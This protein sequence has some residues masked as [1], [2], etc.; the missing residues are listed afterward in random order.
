MRNRSVELRADRPA[1][2]VLVVVVVSVLSILLT[3]C[4]GDDV[5]AD[6]TPGFSASETTVDRSR[7]E[8]ASPDTTAG[9]T[10]IPGPGPTIEGQQPRR[11]RQEDEP[12]F[13]TTTTS[14]TTT[15]TT[16]LPERVPEPTS[17]DRVCRSFFHV[18][19]AVR[20]GQK[21]FLR[22]QEQPG[23]VQYRQIREVVVDGLGAAERTLAP[24]VSGPLGRDVPSA[25]LRRIRTMSEFVASTTSF[26]HGQ[27]LLYPLTTAPPE[28]GETVAWPEIESFIAGTCPEL[29]LALSGRPTLN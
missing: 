18:A 22:E 23:T 29:L 10:T 12:D 13:P 6:G 28:P 20:S 3:A 1:G 26:E 8:L 17:N 24:G 7:F 5:R 14:T 2:A 11:P 19:T 4:G 25:L 21:L 16:T 15:T 27:A 9:P